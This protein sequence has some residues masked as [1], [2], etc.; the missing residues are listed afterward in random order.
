MQYLTCVLKRV[1]VLIFM[2]VAENQVY[3]IN[4]G[5]KAESNDQP[6]G[7]TALSRNL[8][9]YDRS[10]VE[11]NYGAG[12]LED[13]HEEINVRGVPLPPD[14]EA[15]Q[16]SLPSDSDISIHAVSLN[17]DE[18]SLDE[19]S[20][21][22]AEVGFSEAFVV[23]TTR[24]N[25]AGLPQ[26]SA[27]SDRQA[28]VGFMQTAPVHRS[29]DPDGKEGHLLVAPDWES[30]IAH[31]EERIVGSLIEHLNVHIGTRI[32]LS[33]LLNSED[34]RD[35][36]KCRKELITLLN[37]FMEI[38]PEAVRNAY[39]T[40]AS[41]V[42]CDPPVRNAGET[43]STSEAVPESS[44]EPQPGCLCPDEVAE[45]RTASMDR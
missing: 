9:F 16:Y 18:A 1:V 45:N 19:Y 36:E 41:R 8:R 7:A 27:S 39:L 32:Y 13:A 11:I 33:S 34:E 25:P 42:R 35:K 23:I 37:R 31:L 17:N 28:V 20:E 29:T 21:G 43:A 4:D 15:F 3:A 44:P 6:E 22:W 26:S 24:G 30:L 38:L 12:L 2:F 14:L 10:E 5:D 40:L